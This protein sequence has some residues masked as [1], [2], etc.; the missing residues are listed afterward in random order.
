MGGIIFVQIQPNLEQVSVFS[1][2]EPTYPQFFATYPQVAPL[3][4]LG[5]AS[6]YPQ[7]WPFSTSPKPD[8]NR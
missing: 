3:P 4:K 2:V 7:I 8:S 1:T 6:V 5:L